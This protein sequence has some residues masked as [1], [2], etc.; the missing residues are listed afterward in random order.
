[1]TPLSSGWQAAA[2]VGRTQRSGDAEAFR[3]G[4]EAAAESIPHEA[5]NLAEISA[6]SAAG[7]GGTET[8]ATAVTEAALHSWRCGP[9]AT[10]AY[11]RPGGTLD[12]QLAELLGQLSR[13]AADIDQVTGQ[14][15]EA[16]ATGGGAA[17]A[18]VP[19]A[20]GKVAAAAEGD[21]NWAYLQHMIDTLAKSKEHENA[22]SAYLEA[23]SRQLEVFDRLRA[24]V[25]ARLQPD[26]SLAGLPAAGEAGKRREEGVQRLKFDA[27]VD[28]DEVL[29][30]LFEELDADGN[31]TIEME[32]LL[33]LLAKMC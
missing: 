21:S 12:K 17:R 23:V 19:V 18:N 29:L 7:S 31:G 2:V 11:G 3:R 8:A 1:M 5:V 25:A 33:R 16:H 13:F 24:V 30:R 10:P 22:D 27:R 15:S 28:D 9:R 32:E 14:N 4:S 20:V 6:D 26:P